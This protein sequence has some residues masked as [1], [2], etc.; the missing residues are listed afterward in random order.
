[1]FR[2]LSSSIVLW[3]ERGGNVPR[4]RLAP[5]KDDLRDA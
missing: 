4:S 3:K 2:I 1:L 5:R